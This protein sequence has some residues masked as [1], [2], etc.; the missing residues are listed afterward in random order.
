MDLQRLAREDVGRVDV[1]VCNCDDDLQDD[2]V[3]VTARD[4]RG[5]A[6]C[7]PLVEKW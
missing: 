3:F 5:A 7:S 4:G 6:Y 2:V 1:L